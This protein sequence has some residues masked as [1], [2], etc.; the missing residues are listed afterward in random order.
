MNQMKAYQLREV[1]GLHMQIADM[2]KDRNNRESD[3][4]DAK[5]TDI[6]LK[7]TEKTIQMLSNKVNQITVNY[8]KAKQLN[9]TYQLEIKQLKA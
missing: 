1:P 9:N 5:A 2:V 6:K 3:L 7:E 4:N 8:H